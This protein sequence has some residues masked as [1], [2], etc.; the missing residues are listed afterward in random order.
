[1]R[2]PFESSIQ[3]SRL[4]VR[5]NDIYGTILQVLKF[6]FECG[7]TVAPNNITVPQSG[8]HKALI[9]CKV[10]Y[11]WKEFNLSATRQMKVFLHN[12]STFLSHFWS[13]IVNTQLINLVDPFNFVA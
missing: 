11:Y 1:M 12:L 5:M 13:S 7:A 2:D 3:I 8:F 10:R 9:Q 4:R 6:G